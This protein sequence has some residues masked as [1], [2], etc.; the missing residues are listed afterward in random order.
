MCWICR[1]VG[2]KGDSLHGRISGLGKKKDT[3]LSDVLA[4]DVN[5]GSTDTY[6]RGNLIEKP[7]LIDK[8]G[9]TNATFDFTYLMLFREYLMAKQ[10]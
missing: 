6:T 8:E 3:K 7:I 5:Y 10:N 1:G 4:T 2:I 9:S